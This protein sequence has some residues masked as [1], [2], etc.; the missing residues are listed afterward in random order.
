MIKVPSKEGKEHLKEENILTIYR[1]FLASKKKLFWYCRK[2][3]LVLKRYYVVK[4][5]VPS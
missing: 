4:K 1:K 2:K 5:K 3:F